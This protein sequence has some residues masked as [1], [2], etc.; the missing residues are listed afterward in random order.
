[1][2]AAPAEDLLVMA[3][4]VAAQEE[5]HQVTLPV[6]AGV[7]ADILAMAEDRTQT[8][9][10]VVVVVAQTAET[11][12][13]LEQLHLGEESEQLG[14]EQTELVVIPVAAAVVDLMAQ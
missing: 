6:V 3:V 7:Q 4:A 8:E 12:E 1:M 14:K 5:H 13:A 2:P 9:P 11:T 10:V